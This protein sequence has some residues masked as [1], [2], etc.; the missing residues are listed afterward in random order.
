MRMTTVAKRV[1]KDRVQP[2]AEFPGWMAAGP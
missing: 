1:L 2:A